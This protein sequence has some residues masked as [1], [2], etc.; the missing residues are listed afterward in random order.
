MA[1]LLRLVDCRLV[2]RCGYSTCREVWV[3]D[4]S[5]GL[6]I[7]LVERCGYSTCREVWVFDL[8]GGL[9]IRLVGRLGY[10]EEFFFFFGIFL[11]SI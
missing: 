2:G 7:R 11:L 8:S 9:G 3:F 5:G 10:S 4:L 6:G 1:S